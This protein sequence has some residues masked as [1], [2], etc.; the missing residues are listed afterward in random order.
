MSRPAFLPFFDTLSDPRQAWKIAF[1]LDEILL[2]LFLATLSGATSF[3]EMADY[4]RVKLPFLRSFLPFKNGIPSPLTLRRVI[5]ALNPKAFRQCFFQWVQT[6]YTELNRHIA[7][8]GKCLRGSFSKECK[9]VHLVSAWA[10]QTSCLLA[11]SRVNQKSNE[12]T[13]IPEVLAQLC[14][15][16]AVITLDAM[17]CQHEI[18]RQ[19]KEGG[20]DY[21]LALKGNQSSLKEDVVTHLE[22]E[23]SQPARQRTIQQSRTLEKSR[24]RIE[25]RITSV[26]TELDWLRER[27][28]QWSSIQSV[29]CIE[30]RRQI[31][32]QC[33]SERRYYVSSL[34]ESPQKQGHWVRRHWG[35]ENECHWVLDVVFR[36]DA[37]RVREKGGA[38]N[39]HTVR[40]FALSN[41]RSYVK[42]AGAER[43]LSY[44]RCVQ[45]CGW[46]ESILREVL[47]TSPPQHL[48]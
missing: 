23:L 44:R 13:A 4:G 42:G 19:I 20:G 27:H 14:L 11:Q 31:G 33:R 46:D 22:A 15:T 18:A 39:L 2:L 37:S 12:I 24:N 16:G 21:I 45:L 41:I 35:I 25:T 28:P 34:K 47:Q 3:N 8:D 32:T 38:E 26:S 10:S 1:P 7:I 40:Q 30:S 6:L 17:G 5:E 9:S 43:K 48:S 29:L 36:E